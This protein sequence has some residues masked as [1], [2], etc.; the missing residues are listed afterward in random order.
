M[1]SPKIKE[2]LVVRLFRIKQQT[3]KPM[4]KHVNA[5]IREYVQKF[6]QEDSP[7]NDETH[8]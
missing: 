8:E 2:D 5:A 1:Y 3:G 7:P 6:E 4:T